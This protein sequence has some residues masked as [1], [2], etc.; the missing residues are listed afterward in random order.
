[1]VDEPRQAIEEALQQPEDAQRGVSA[2][3]W[4]KR[5]KSASGTRSPAAHVGSRRSRS[6]SPR[7]AIIIRLREALAPPQRQQLQR[8]GGHVF[9]GDAGDEGFLVAAGVARAILAADGAV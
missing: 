4:R 5:E 2:S 3:G 7:R 9:D 6:L 1:M 8:G